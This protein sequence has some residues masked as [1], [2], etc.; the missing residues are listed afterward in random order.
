MKQLV[1]NSNSVR[2]INEE[3]EALKC[4]SKTFQNE[5]GDHSSAPPHSY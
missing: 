2:Q 5:S 3:T 1:C 4:L